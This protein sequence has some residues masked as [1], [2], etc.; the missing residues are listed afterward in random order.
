[1]SDHTAREPGWTARF[2]TTLQRLT[3][4]AYNLRCDI[5]AW[6]VLQDDG[7]ELVKRVPLFAVCASTLQSDILI[8]L[9]RIFDFHPKAPSLWYLL[10]HAPPP[11]VVD[12][13]DRL[14]EF[15]N[16][17]KKIRD[18]V[19]VHIDRD[20]VFNPESIYRAA[21]IR[22]PEI[23]ENVDTLWEI[24]ARLQRETFENASHSILDR[25]IDQLQEVY[26]RDLDSLTGTHPR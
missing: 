22:V 21:N 5:A 7:R 17:L 10:R 20:G 26:R 16:Q 3:T 13:I 4:E 25:T 19:F 2:N 6:A 8:R 12:G 11:E 23:R 9:I 14:A 18:R 1:M 24:L 15:S